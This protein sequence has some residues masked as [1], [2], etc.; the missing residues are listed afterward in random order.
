MFI[1]GV[2]DHEAESK[3]KAKAVTRCATLQCRRA[4]PRRAPRLRRLSAFSDFYRVIGAAES[5]IDH[6][7]RVGQG[8]GATHRAS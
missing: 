2:L 8:R 1:N 6:A 5:I 7:T 3:N 4:T